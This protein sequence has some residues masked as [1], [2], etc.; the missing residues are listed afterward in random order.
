MFLK[1][2]DDGELFELDGPDDI[3]GIYPYISSPRGGTGRSE[4]YIDVLLL[5]GDSDAYPN[6]KNYYLRIAKSELTKVE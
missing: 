2:G 1:K 4:Q 6:A 5:N 3:T